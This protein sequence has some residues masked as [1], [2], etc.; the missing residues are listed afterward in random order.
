MALVATRLA[1]QA[2][3]DAYVEAIA[4]SS[5]GLV[6]HFVIHNGLAGVLLVLLYDNDGSEIRRRA[7]APGD[8]VFAVPPGR[9][10][11]WKSDKLQDFSVGLSG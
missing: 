8:H 1:T 5:D 3:G 2:D 4:E 6:S 9:A 10:L 7:F 11:H